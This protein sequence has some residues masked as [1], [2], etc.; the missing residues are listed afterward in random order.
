MPLTN[1]RSAPAPTDENVL[2]S[3]EEY[4]TSVDVFPLALAHRLRPGLWREYPVVAILPQFGHEEI[5]KLIRFNLLKDEIQKDG[6]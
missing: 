4:C 2:V 3:A 1:S 5:I 6:N